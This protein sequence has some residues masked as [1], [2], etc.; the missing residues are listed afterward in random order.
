MN[1]DFYLSS[2]MLMIFI[3]IVC[4][5]DFCLIQAAQIINTMSFG[6]LRKKRH[7]HS[8]KSPMHHKLVSVASVWLHPFPILS[9]FFNL[10]TEER[11]FLAWMR[12]NLFFLTANANS[13][14]SRTSCG[15]QR[16]NSQQHSN[17]QTPASALYGTYEEPAS[18]GTVSSHGIPL[19]HLLF[20]QVV[21][22]VNMLE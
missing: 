10:E 22:S 8:Q 18:A 17:Y 5:A 19:Y 11:S 4:I 21:V 15:S 16:G 12:F 13:S 6:F 3:G 20:D 14:T 1:T 2:S 9:S 7:L